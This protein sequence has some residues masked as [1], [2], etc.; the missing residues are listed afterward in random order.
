VAIVYLVRHASHSRVHDTLVGRMPGVALSEGGQAEARELGERLNRRRIDAIWTSPVQ[1]A[2]E[3]AQAVSARVGAPVTVDEGLIEIDF[4]ADW[5]GR[6][7]ADLSAD[8]RWT[9]WNERRGSAPTPAGD[10]MPKVQERITDALERARSAH[11]AGGVVFVSHGDVIKAALAGV[12]GLSLDHHHRFEVG[13]ASVSAVAVEEWG[14]KVLSI[15]EV[16]A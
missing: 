11:P 2:R 15:N 4:G 8:P 13:P 16:A 1:R 10:S 9:L 6:R 3:T 14:T 5:I 7:F 12:L